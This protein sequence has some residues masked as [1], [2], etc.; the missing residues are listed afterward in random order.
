MKQRKHFLLVVLLLCALVLLCACGSEAEYSVKVVSALG[1]PY[2]GVIVQFMQDGQRVAMQAVDENGVAAKSLEKG[3]Y[4]VELQFTDSNVSY[5]YG[6]E[7]LTLS[8]Q[9]RSLTVELAQALSGPAETLYVGGVAVEAHT[10]DVGCT[11][12]PLAASGRTYVIFN[13]AVPGTYAVSLQGEAAV[14]Y[15]G[16]PHF[17]Q[18]NPAVETVDNTVTLSVNAGM[19]G[20]DS[21]SAAMLVL[22]V[23]AAAGETGC[24]LTVERVGDPQETLADKPW[25][26]YEA[27]VELK[28]FTLPAGTGLVDFDLTAADD[29]YTLVLNEDDGFYHMNTADGPLVLVRLGEPSA[30]LDSIREVVD[31]SGVVKYFFD[32]NGEFVKKESYTECL[33]EYLKYVDAETGVYPPWPTKGD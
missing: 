31:K 11:Y 23:D 21:T 20:T 27:T 17:V 1:D 9:E 14:G 30:Y 6:E 25:T 13:P 22:G 5:Y 12:L 8:E 15:Y 28:Q 19:I 16:T 10:V 4:T 26:I 18:E 24:V 32:E 33:I 29:A 2:Q 3:E 7:T